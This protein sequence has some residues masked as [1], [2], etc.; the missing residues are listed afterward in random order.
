MI[1]AMYSCSRTKSTSQGQSQMLRGVLAAWQTA[2]VSHATQIIRS[3]AA[4]CGRYL[5][6]GSKNTPKSAADQSEGRQAAG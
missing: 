5:K 2:R 6:K 1:Y 4:N 3:F